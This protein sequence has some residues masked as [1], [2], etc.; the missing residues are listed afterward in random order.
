MEKDML[1]RKI[2]SFIKEFFRR[3]KN[4]LLITG[5]RQIGKT[6]S[7]REF[8]KKF[9]SFIEIN[10]VEN[11]S[12]VE[13]FKTAKNS[14]DIL[15]R[16]SAMTNIP[17]I[18]GKTLI[19]FDEVQKCPEIVTA[20]KF[21]VEEGSY[22]YIL[23][24][25]LLGV[26]LRDLRSVP[27]GYLEVKDMYPL[28]FEEF[29]ICNNVNKAIISHIK[30]AFYEKR[31]VDDVIHVKLLELF[32]LY[33]VVGGM[34]AA[35]SKY[36]ETNNLQEVLAVQQ[37]IIRL[38]KWD[39]SQY[40]YKNKL[41]IEEIFD[42]IPSELNAKNKRF[43]LKSLNQNAKFTY[44]E[45]SFLWLKNA[46]VA[47]PVY[48]VEEPKVPLLLAKSRNLFKLF[49][50][51]VGLLAAQYSD[52][53]QLK[54]IMGQSDINFGAI[55]ENAVAQELAAHDF[56]LYY[57]NSKKQGE[58]DFVVEKDGMILPIEVKSGKDYAVHRALTNI[59][60]NSEY[61]IKEALVLSNANI[62]QIGKILYAPIY[63]VMLIEK[64]K[65]K[66]L[67]Y[68]IDLSAVS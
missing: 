53:I 49:Q 24:G 14:A 41:K 64:K 45:D 65:E 3:S 52:G 11:Q 15:L 21:L 40:A 1:K 42:L 26:E 66:P 63:M 59:L 17:L 50:S 39:I 37:E 5:A 48:N 51:D 18:K 67:I 61:N 38:Y 43:I 4:A 57:F 47:L 28:D 31:S 44:Y 62:K 6:F 54:I 68:K 56:N 12:A 60:E 46:G 27:V 16:L 19:F 7:V 36:L 23:S 33:L 25:S 2:D 32:R 10:F 8:G 29:L 9:E 13:I 55:Y 35:V 20:I 22:R 34:P 58:L 30:D